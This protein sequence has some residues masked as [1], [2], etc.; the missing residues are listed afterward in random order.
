MI[1]RVAMIDGLPQPQ[2]IAVVAVAASFGGFAYHLWIER[3][4]SARQRLGGVLLSGF[5][6][7][8]A[9]LWLHEDFNSHL[10]LVAASIIIGGV[11][12][13]LLDLLVIKLTDRIKRLSDVD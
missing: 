13:T 6:G 4:I 12:T 8:L 2:A 3:K 5:I 11:G 10:K 1:A 7:A 9:Y